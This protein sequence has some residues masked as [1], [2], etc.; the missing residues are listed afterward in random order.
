VSSHEWSL[1]HVGSPFAQTLATSHYGTGYRI[2]DRE[3]SIAAP[4]QCSLGR[5]Y[6]TT[7][8][9]M[10]L[11]RPACP[12]TMRPWVERLVSKLATVTP[13]HPWVERLLSKLVTV[14]YRSALCSGP[15]DADYDVTV[16]VA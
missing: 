4:N 5:F 6:K 8:R 2:Q 9:G 3:P 7:G 12:R 1:Q 13:V 16:A 14:I 11:D 10:P 15:P